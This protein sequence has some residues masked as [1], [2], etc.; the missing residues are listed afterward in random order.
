MTRR[1]SGVQREVLSLYRGFIRA[2]K[3]KPEPAQALAV[4]TNRF[5]HEASTTKRMDF[6][7]IEF[8]MR[9][10]KKQLKMLQSPNVTNI[11]SF[12]VPPPGAVA[13]RMCLCWKGRRQVAASPIYI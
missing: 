2:A 9:Q 8:M 10:G 13:S 6:R 1:L 11:N 5:R 4:V 12:Y 3:T 7:K